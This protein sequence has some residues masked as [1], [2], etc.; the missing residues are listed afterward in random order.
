MAYAHLVN[1]LAGECND[2]RFRVAPGDPANSYLLDK[3]LGVDMCSGVQM[4]QIG[5][6]GED[7]LPNADLDVITAWVCQGAL[8]N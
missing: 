2:G 4:P 1:V 8:D 7:T 5:G 3:V 6:P